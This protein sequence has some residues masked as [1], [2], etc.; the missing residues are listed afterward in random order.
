M[1][2]ASRAGRISLNPGTCPPLPSPTVGV[3][4]PGAH[5]PPRLPLD[6]PREADVAPAAG[7]PL[8]REGHQAQCSVP[9]AWWALG[10]GQPS[11]GVMGPGSSPRAVAGTLGR[12]GGGVLWPHTTEAISWLFSVCRRSAQCCSHKSRWPCSR[13]RRA[14]SSNTWDEAGCDQPGS[15]MGKLGLVSHSRLVHFY[16]FHLQHMSPAPPSPP[17]IPRVLPTNL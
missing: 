4:S 11:I 17:V 16:S 1:G 10:V 6:W 3:V 2:P 7:P 9:S 13:W 8:P 5:Q 14:S 12:A 15:I